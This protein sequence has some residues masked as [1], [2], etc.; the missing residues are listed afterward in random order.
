MELDMPKLIW[1]SKNQGF[2]MCFACGH[3]SPGKYKILT[4]HSPFNQCTPNTPTP[5]DN[6]SDRGS[7][8]PPAVVIQFTSSFGV[9]FFFWILKETCFLGLAC[10]LCCKAIVRSSVLYGAVL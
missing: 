2:S 3:E 5:L 4:F 7:T 6:L 10:L 8:I 1:V 9:H